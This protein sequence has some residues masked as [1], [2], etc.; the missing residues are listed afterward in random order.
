M[1]PVFKLFAI[2]NLFY[3]V[4]LKLKYGIELKIINQKPGL[5]RIT[6][7]RKFSIDI[8]SHLKSDTYIESSGG[9]TIGKYFH[10]G[11]GFTVLTSNHNF[12]DSEFIPYDNKQILESVVIEDFVWIGAEVIILPGVTIGEGAIIG[13]GSIITK[14]VETLTIVAGNPA[15]VIGTRDK[16]KYLYQKKS[17]KY[18]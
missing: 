16:D 14:D 5:V 2:A 7:P 12:R 10:V 8:M 3:M 11:S 15:R 6:E 4:I 9:V 13:A 17:G 18:N 1:N